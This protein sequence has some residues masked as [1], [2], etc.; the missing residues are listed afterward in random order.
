MCW[1]SVIA[2]PTDILDE[3][4]GALETIWTPEWASIFEQ[5]LGLGLLVLVLVLIMILLYMVQIDGSAAYVGLGSGSDA[6]NPVVGFL[7][8][9]LVRY[10]VWDS[11]IV[12]VISV[13]VD[14]L[15]FS[16]P[17]HLGPKWRV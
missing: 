10:S 2:F 14:S 1:G 3:D 9:F 15:P 6:Y 4:T 8:S 5:V 12:R 7:V 17:L 13:E 11:L 16:S